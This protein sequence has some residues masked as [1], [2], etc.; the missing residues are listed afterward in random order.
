MQVLMGLGSTCLPTLETHFQ[1][2]TRT[3][4]TAQSHR[5]GGWR[6]LTV[7]S[8]P[9]ALACLGPDTIPDMPLEAVLMSLEHTPFLLPPLA[10]LWLW[11]QV[12][13]QRKGVGQSHITHCADAPL[14]TWGGPAQ[15]TRTPRLELFSH[16]L[17]PCLSP[18]SSLSLSPLPPSL[19]LSFPVPPPICLS[20][21]FSLI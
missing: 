19:S 8:P 15:P 20:L 12:C 13:L 16:P 6:Q 3:A 18:S 11:F 9:T 4:V 7:L 14:R 5:W 10:S 1:Y 17:F 2:S 21:P